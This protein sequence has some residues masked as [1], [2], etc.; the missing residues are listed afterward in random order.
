MGYSHPKKELSVAMIGGKGDGSY[1]LKLKVINLSTSQV[2]TRKYSVNFLD[3]NYSETILIK[4]N[5][6]KK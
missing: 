4:G 5:V 2:I 3:K 6:S 1:L